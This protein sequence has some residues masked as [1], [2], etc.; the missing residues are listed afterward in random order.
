MTALHTARPRAYDLF[1][2][3]RRGRRLALAQEILRQASPERMVEG[4][5]ALTPASTRSERTHL[6]AT[7]RTLLQAPAFHRLIEDAAR[8][9]LNAGDFAHLLA[10]LG[11][12][13]DFKAAA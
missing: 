12:A 10:E 11:L 5:R 9:T 4:L 1:G 2:P 3:S 6:F 7:I 13:P 8:P